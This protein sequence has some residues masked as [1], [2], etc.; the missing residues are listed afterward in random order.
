M[1]KIT[2]WFLWKNRCLKEFE[3]KDQNLSSTIFSVK[4]MLRLC[5]DQHNHTSTQSLTQSLIHWS[6]PVTDELKLNFDTSFDHET[7]YVGMS[8]I[9]RNS[10]GSCEGIRGRNFHGGIDPEHAE[11]LAFKE[12]IL[13]ESEIGLQKVNFE[14]D[15]LNVVNSVEYA[16]SSVHWMN[17]GLVNEIRQLL[18]KLSCCKVNYVKRQTNNVAHVIAHKARTGRHS[19]EYHCNIPDIFIEEIRKDQSSTNMCH[20]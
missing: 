11:C 16:K 20:M 6:P 9:L 10:T 1:A 15:C 14:G 17:E 5:G 13:W 3:N 2:T 19:F 12:A 7:S 18:S 8:L 4:N